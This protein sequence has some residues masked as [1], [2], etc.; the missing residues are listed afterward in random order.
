VGLAAGPG[1][2]QVV[3]ASAEGELAVWDVPRQEKQFSWMVEGPV[4]SV[5]AALGGPIAVA[6]SSGKVLLFPWGEERGTGD[7]LSVDVDSPVDV[8]LS[9]DGAMLSVTDAAGEVHLFRVESKGSAVRV[10]LVG[11]V[12]MPEPKDHWVWSKFSPDGRSLVTASPSAVLKCWTVPGLAWV[13]TEHRQHPVKD[14]A[15]DAHAD[16][17]VSVSAEPTTLIDSVPHGT[18]LASLMSGDSAGHSSVV[19]SGD[20]KNLLLGQ[21]DGTLSVWDLVVHQEI[22]HDRT[23]LEDVLQMA[24]TFNGE[25]LLLL[26][27]DRLT[28][29]ALLLVRSA[30]VRDRPTGELPLGASPSER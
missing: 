27:R 7:Q 3:T 25:Q 23:P 12:P 1:V 15:F 9:A 2:K 10:E 21:S 11:R 26:G 16:A 29:E 5:D 19:F 6:S 8:A 18:R 4:V 17:M 13:R 28:G 22:F 24:M 14:L 30:K 20:G